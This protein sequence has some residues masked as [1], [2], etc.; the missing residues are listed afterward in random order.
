MTVCVHYDIDVK[1]CSTNGYKMQ[2]G[3]WIALIDAKIVTKKGLS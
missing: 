3:F 1:Y 2:R